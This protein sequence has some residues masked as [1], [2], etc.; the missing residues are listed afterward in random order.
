MWFLKSQQILFM[1]SAV[2]ILIQIAEYPHPSLG[3]A[4]EFFK[5]DDASGGRS[6][7]LV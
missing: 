2:G 5:D 6:K 3:P 4:G 7:N 1:E